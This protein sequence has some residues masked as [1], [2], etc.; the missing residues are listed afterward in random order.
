MTTI[1]LEEDAKTVRPARRW[2]DTPIPMPVL[3]VAMFAALGSSHVLLWRFL[4]IGSIALSAAGIFCLCAILWGVLRTPSDVVAAQAPSLRAWFTCVGIATVLLMLSGEGRFFYANVDWQVRNAVLHDMSVNPW[5]FVYLD[6][7]TE[8]LL[9]APLGMYFLPAASAKLLGDGS[10]D[11]VLLVQNALL[12][13]TMLTAAV[14]LFDR[15]RD[16]LLALAVFVAFSG[17]DVVGAILAHGFTLDHLELWAGRLEYSSTITLMFWVPQHAIAGWFGTVCYLLWRKGIVPARL[18]LIATP[19]AVLWSPLAMIGLVPFAAHAGLDLVFRR[20]VRPLD[21]ALPA[22]AVAVSI[23]ALR[24][25]GADPDAVGFHHY[26][27]PL[28]VWALFLLIEVVPFI[29]PLAVV[30][31]RQ[32]RLDPTFAIVTAILVFVPFVQVGAAIDLMMRASIPALAILAVFVTHRLLADDAEYRRWLVIMLVI[33]GAT[34][35][36]ELSRAF[37]EPP[38]P[39]THC[40]MFDAWDYGSKVHGGT[41]IPKGSYLARLDL[42]PAMVR[43]HAPSIA[44]AYSGQSCWTSPWPRPSGI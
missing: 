28:V 37:R 35:A 1:T 26:D 43:P 21:I 36:M 40:T 44:P 29:Y 27:I 41:P 16:R 8:L 6:G 19:L 7:Q 12:I 24:Y 9:R 14:P 17:L 15:T 42:V 22:L 5:P 20:T 18:V 38:A 25:L 2:L 23:P 33:G 11:I 39:A 4:G 31:V 10:A 13:G 34:G 30:A 3:L 32:R